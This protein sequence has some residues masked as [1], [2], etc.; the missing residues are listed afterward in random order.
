MHPVGKQSI[1]LYSDDDDFSLAGKDILGQRTKPKV[2][3]EVIEKE[4]SD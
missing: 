4:K 1:L 3:T 2:V